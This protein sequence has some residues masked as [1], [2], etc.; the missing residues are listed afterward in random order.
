MACRIK[1]GRAALNDA[2]TGSLIGIL[3]FLILLSAFFSSSE[4]A[5][6]SLNRFRLKHLRKHHRGA[7]RAARLLDR[8]D[9]LIGLIL[10][11]N[12][13]VN[14]LAALVAGIIFARWFG[15]EAGLWLTTILLTFIMLVFAEVTPKTIAA[16]HPEKLAF[17]ASRILKVLL[18][19][20]LPLVVFVN[21][22]TNALARLFGVEP[23]VAA[24]EQISPDELRTVVDE[25]GHLIPDQHQD[26][27]INILDL[28]K[29][30]VNDIMIPRH[31]IV[32]LDL[33]QDIDKLLRSILDS[34][35]TRLPVYSGDINNVVGTLHLRRMN[36]VLR[37]G[38]QKVTKEA[39]KRF[40]REPYFI[41]ENTPLTTQ[42]VNFQKSRRRIGFVVDEYG[43]VEGLVTLDD[44]LE[45]IVGEYTTNVDD[46]EE[47]FT[48]LSDVEILV[49]GRASLRDFNKISGWQLP[50]DGP[51]TLSGYMIEHLEAI[52]E[53]PACHQQGNLRF[54][55]LEVADKVILKV[56]V[57]AYKANPKKEEDES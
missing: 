13:A 9:R 20:A 30:S 49:D 38:D 35:F 1:K 37:S 27:L 12:N 47:E 22:M 48:R 41:P 16:L 57:W 2:S 28:E 52:P 40:T 6:M 18:F 44:I 36:R 10:I 24:G 29:V 23:T 54:E 33:E 25:A 46:S 45:E 43:E 56:R 39:I 42:L 21:W 26:M 51:R 17:P 55:V 34:D 5:M 32:G 8:P 31:E 50:T 3:V 14:I 53:G 11:G 15:E 19:L 4:T 7:R